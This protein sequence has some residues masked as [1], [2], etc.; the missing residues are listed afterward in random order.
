VNGGRARRVQMGETINGMLVSDVR[1]DRV[2]LTMGDE[3]EELTLKVAAGP[4]T[5]VQPVVAASPVPGAPV[6]GAPQAQ[7]QSAGA[8]QPPVAQDVADVL[9]NRRRAARAAEAA[10][11]S[12]AAG[13]P[14]PQPAPPATPPPARAAPPQ[15]PADPAWN[16]L[17]QRYMQPRR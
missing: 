3:S 8:Q 12:A 16:E 5:T 15:Q 1:A 9:A 11:S 17:Y 10:A 6:A 4:R 2:K 7:P 13:Q 14:A